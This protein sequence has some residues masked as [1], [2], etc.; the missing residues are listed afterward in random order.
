M[1]FKVRTAI[2]AAD[3]ASELEQDLLLQLQNQ[4]QADLSFVFG[5]PRQIARFSGLSQVKALSKL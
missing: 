1:R 2:S 4:Q 5:S 3:P